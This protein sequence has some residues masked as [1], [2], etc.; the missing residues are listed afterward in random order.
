MY[1]CSIQ[2]WKNPTSS[3]SS[4]SNNDR[5]NPPCAVSDHQ[6]QTQQQQPGDR[7]QTVMEEEDE[8]DRL[9]ESDVP[10]PLPSDRSS[11]GQD[12]GHQEKKQTTNKGVFAKD[13]RKL[14]E[15]R[16][17]TGVAKMMGHEADE[18]TVKNTSMNEV[19]E[20]VERNIRLEDTTSSPDQTKERAESDS[21]KIS[22]EDRTLPNASSTSSSS[23]KSTLD[24]SH[25]E[26][27][28]H[29]DDASIC[30]R[31]MGMNSIESESQNS[32][33]S[34]KPKESAFGK[35]NNFQFPSSTESK[36]FPG[37]LKP[38]KPTVP[39]KPDSAGR[40]PWS[41][42]ASSNPKTVS[43]QRSEE[44]AKLIDRVSE[45]EKQL[46]CERKEN[47]ATRQTVSER[48]DRIRQ[49]E[50]EMVALNEDLDLADEDYLRLEEENQALVHALVQA[51]ASTPAE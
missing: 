12:G 20:A 31:G 23:D 16:R 18:E 1:A 32:I 2:G 8:V 6:Q 29:D 9:E 33:K 19:V 21:S 41:R 49:L 42:E 17:S 13:K 5:V 51:T 36:R 46:Q 30:N 28:S 24:G 48:D 50:L 4:S 22:D 7:I 26:S 38:A 14:R 27:T 11:D 35:L 15:K 40:L 39:T 47:A 45:L 37:I 3:S 34:E 43:G 25:S 44:E 10:A